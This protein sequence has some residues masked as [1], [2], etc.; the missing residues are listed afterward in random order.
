MLI[1]IYRTAIMFLSVLVTMRLLGKRQ[2][3]Q[4]E[5]SELVVAIMVSEFAVIPVAN[6]ER[7]LLDGIIPVSVLLVCELGIAFFC[8]KSVRLR[9]FII[10][11]PSILL[12]DGQIVQREMR[13]NRLT[14]TELSEKLRIQGYTDFSTLKYVVLEVNGTM[15]AIP[16]AAHSPAT[17]AAHQLPGEDKGLPVLVINDGRLLEENLHRLGL[18][19]RWLEKE[20][21]RRGVPGY[22]QVF[23]LT[24]DEKRNIYFATK[25]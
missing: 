8:M 21:K 9:S 23:I 18:D 3:G 10:G 17:H 14:V 11:K 7:S 6:P 25:T 4:L 5:L 24:V 12:H 20:L 19:Q 1:L 16:Y 2:L 13:K 15:S 22:E